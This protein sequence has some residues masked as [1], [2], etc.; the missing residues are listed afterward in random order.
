M[1]DKVGKGLCLSAFIWLYIIDNYMFARYIRDS[2]VADCTVMLIYRN[3]SR[4]Y[5][6]S[7]YMSFDITELSWPG[8]RW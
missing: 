1:T 4:G 7:L 6:Q 3:F 8:K 2:H 5:C